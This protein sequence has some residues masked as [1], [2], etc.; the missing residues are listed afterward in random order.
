VSRTKISYLIPTLNEAKNIGT[1]IQKILQYSFVEKIILIDGGSHDDTV[2]IAEQYPIMI[3][4]Q[5]SQG[6]GGAIN[7]ALKYLE[8]SDFVI[9]IDGDNTYDPAEGEKFLPLL[10][11]GKLI[12][13]SRF[14]GTIYPGSMTYLNR[15]GNKW[16]NQC[17]NRYYHAHITDF[18]SG[19]KGFLVEDILNLH[20]QA[21]NFEI[22][23]EL[24][25]KASKQLDI[26]ELPI[27]YYP[28][29]GVSKLHP[30]KDGYRIYRRL[31]T[32]REK[33]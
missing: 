5:Q 16:L 22:E 24:M 26:I 19:M 27:N 8:P 4:K 1:L 6:K 25:I 23:T 17:F 11:K 9:L 30:F 18:M 20:L 14:L 33:R 32:E 15:L 2:K 21:T 3:L 10:S 28:R 31:R 13:G 29:G 12:N 7:E